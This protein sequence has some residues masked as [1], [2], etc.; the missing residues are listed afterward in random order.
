[1]RERLP[2]AAIGADVIAGFPGE[3]E[4]D[5]R[6]TLAFIE[7]V[8]LTYLHV[9]SFSARP[10]TPAAELAYQVSR[11]V[12]DRRAAELRALGEKKKAGFLASQVGAEVRALTLKRAGTDAMGPWT[13]AL[14]SNYLNVRVAGA[15]PANQFL[16]VRVAGVRKDELVGS[17]ASVDKP[18]AEKRKDVLLQGPVLPEESAVCFGL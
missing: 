4:E 18:A 2:S 6:E 16:N 9:F 11:D 7:R 14:T 12:I 8:P 15:F 5:H 10:G 3:T 13:R 17:V 1:V